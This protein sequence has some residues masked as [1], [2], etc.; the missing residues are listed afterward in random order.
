MSPSPL[1][2]TT[3]TYVNFTHQ[4]HTAGSRSDSRPPV[5]PLPATTVASLTAH[6][7][8]SPIT[9]HAPISSL[10]QTE[11]VV[12]LPLQVHVHVALSTHTLFLLL[13]LTTLLLVCYRC[14]HQEWCC[15]LP[16]KQCLAVPSTHRDHLSLFLMVAASLS[17][18]LTMC[19]HQYLHHCR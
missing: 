5:P 19:P 8:P 1:L 9:S 6:T 14:Q 17:L 13:S 12:S 15:L 4:S 3:S 7:L 11:D 2:V 16:V 18:K 10:L